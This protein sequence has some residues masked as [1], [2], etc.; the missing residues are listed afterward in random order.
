MDQAWK[1]CTPLFLTVFE[2]HRHEITDLISKAKIDW[3]TDAGLRRMH[4]MALQEN[5]S[6]AEM[7]M[8]TSISMFKNDIDAV[9]ECFKRLCR[10]EFN[11]STVVY[12]NSGFEN[13]QMA[14]C[15][16]DRINGT[17]K[18]RVDR[19]S[20]MM[21]IL[22]NGSAIG[23][24]MTR[25]AG[26]GVETF[27]GINKRTSGGVLSQIQY[28]EAMLSFVTTRD[29][30]TGDGVVYLHA[31]HHD[32][33][34]C[35]SYFNPLSNPHADR[36]MFGIMMNDLLWKL[37]EKKE[38]IWYLFSGAEELKLLVEAVGDDFERVY[39]RLVSEKR[40][41]SS[42]QAQ[43]FM[44]EIVRQMFASGKIYIINCDT[45]NKMSN[46]RHLG[47]IENS[48]LCAE[49]MQVANDEIMAICTLG[50]MS[51]PYFCDADER[52]FDFTTFRESVEFLTKCV[53][54]MVDQTYVSPRAQHASKYR[55]I[56]IG[57]SGLTDVQIMM[58]MERDSSAFKQLNA[59]IYENI[60]YGALSMSCKL[61]MKN[62]P[63]Y[64]FEQTPI[65]RGLF[66]FDLYDSNYGNKT[67]TTL[68]WNTLRKK[69]QMYGVRNSLVTC[70]M[71][72][73]GS[74]I[75]MGNTESFEPIYA[76]YYSADDGFEPI[77]NKHLR[78][79]L[80]GNIPF[81]VK[82]YIMDNRG[83]IQNC[84]YIDTSLAQLFKTSFEVDF[85]NEIELSADRA[86]F[87]DQSQSFNIYVDAASHETNEKTTTYLYQLLKYAHKLGLKTGSY[88][89]RTRLRNHK[90]NFS[91]NGDETCASCVI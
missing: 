27:D 72:T 25:N 20:S 75:I 37:V 59:A 91:F 28:F 70:A 19:Y 58:R 41:S 40:Y 12:R 54:T 3:I 16:L 45:V 15:F 33:L 83:S 18:Q 82:Q 69:I 63:H 30:K 68:D 5:E 42:I 1:R 4:K 29:T 8:R 11:F 23:I 35:I 36:C 34:E 85:F 89:T 57:A 32:L 90:M 81:R 88:Y 10:G 48:N 67:T 73:A 56:G 46:Q 13:N 77:F 24:G 66:Q 51:L 79:L 87:I 22:N 62:G 65:S 52:S 6:P 2:N 61:A 84:P 47:V 21:E 86:R 31:F 71:P 38:S 44:E 7:F 50:T 76:T 14:S 55:A 17:F 78:R 53:D 60:Y 74:S 26:K 9:V 39:Y 49:I 43:E 80:G 64:E